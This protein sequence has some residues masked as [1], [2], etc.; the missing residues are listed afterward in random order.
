MQELRVATFTRGSTNKQTNRGKA[1]KASQSKKAS[2]REIMVDNDLPLQKEMI[3]HFIDSQP[4]KDKGIHWVMTDLEYVEAGVSGFHTHV[5][6]RKSTIP[7][8]IF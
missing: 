7:N 6:K 5:S 4:E 8:I 2:S 3:R 1:K